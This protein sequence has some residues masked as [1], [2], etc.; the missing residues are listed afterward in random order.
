M[1][2]CFL[3]RFDRCRC[4]E[5]LFFFQRFNFLRNKKKKINS[6]KE[7]GGDSNQVYFQV[8][9]SLLFFSLSYNY[10]EFESVKTYIKY[11]IQVKMEG[12]RGKNMKNVK[13]FFLSS[14]ENN[15]FLK[16]KKKI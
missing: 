14:L 1:C 10:K 16:Y 13:Q 11:I 9:W 4:N 12:R 2:V 6:R 5:Y 3:I 15:F 7:E 8:N